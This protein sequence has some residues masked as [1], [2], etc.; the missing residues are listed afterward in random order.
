MMKRFLLFSLIILLFSCGDKVPKDILSIQQMQ[1]IQWDLMRAD[2]M[3]DYYRASDTLYRPEQKREEYYSKIFS[4]HR[5]S[6]EV[7]KRSLDY[8][9]ARPK[10]LKKILDAMHAKAEKQAS[11]DTA[12]PARDTALLKRDTARIP[13]AI[14]S[15]KRKKLLKIKR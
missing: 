7:F 8:Y 15:L 9:T 12:K 5:T 3:V 10:E 11:R 14:D 6:K 13:K 4:I 1:D 2:E